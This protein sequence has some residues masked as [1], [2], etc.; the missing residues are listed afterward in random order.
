MADNGIT[1]RGTLTINNSTIRN[2]SS[3]G[4]AIYMGNSSITTLTGGTVVEHTGNGYGIHMREA[5]TDSVLNLHGATIKSNNN[6]LDGLATVVNGYCTVNIKNKNEVYTAPGGTSIITK[7]N[8]VYEAGS[9]CSRT[10][11]DKVVNG[12]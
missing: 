12:T 10:G 7:T 8:W 2:I 3:S 11:A 5:N 9:S 1:N 6:G 4:I